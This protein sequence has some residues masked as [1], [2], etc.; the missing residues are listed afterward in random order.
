MN[1]EEFI[2][3]LQA[4]NIDVT[5]DKLNKLKMYY[6]YLIEYNNH[7]NLTAI[8]EEKEV[9]LK[10]FYDSLTLTKAYNLNNNISMLDIGSGAGFPGIVIKIFYPNIN[11]TVIDSNNKKTTF[12]SSLI[13]KLQLDNINVIND[14]AEEYAKNH[15]NEFDLVT[16]RA[17]A[18]VDI[19]TSI[20]LPFVKV[21]G[22][23]ILMKGSFEN[24][25]R[26]L[27]NHLHDLNVKDYQIINFNLPNTNDERNLVILTKINETSKVLQ[28]N[29]IIKRNKKWNN[30]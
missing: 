8:T 7:T 4:M 21:D 25:E 6:N 29:Q 26:I 12:I 13:D 27:K 1:N 30:K 16:S 24:E 9:Y 17:V 2:L 28:F 14:R 20:S 23:L 18:F 22:K 15:L 5:D 10:H 11:L 19:I 3:G